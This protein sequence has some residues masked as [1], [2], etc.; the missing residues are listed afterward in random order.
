MQYADE[1]KVTNEDGLDGVD[2]FGMEHPKYKKI[3]KHSSLSRYYRCLD[4]EL[5]KSLFK[6]AIVRNPWDQM[7]SH[8][9]SPYRGVDTWNRSDFIQMVKRTAPLSYYL[10]NRG[11][12]AH[13]LKRKGLFF[14]N[15]RALDADL[16]MVLRFERLNDDYRQLCE[17][18]G[19][20]YEPLPQVNKSKRK[21]S[22]DYYD[23]EL[24]ELIAKHFRKEIEFF[25]Y[26]FE[27]LQS[28]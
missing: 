24:V 11:L 9:F 21:R 1:Q 25:G 13:F 3:A 12:A 16:D 17:R 19:I 26:R 7:I 15:G 18:L 4:A 5:Y 2:R 27:D 6:F 22:V 14:E 20:P 28:L 10:Q 23:D 8:Y